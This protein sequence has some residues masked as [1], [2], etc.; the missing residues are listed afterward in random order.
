MVAAILLGA[1]SI[2][3]TIRDRASR[4]QVAVR[5]R[6]ERQT[7]LAAQLELI[8]A[9]ATELLQRQRWSESLSSAKR[10]EAIIAG[11]ETDGHL[12]QLVRALLRELQLVERMDRARHR[13]T[14]WA[15]THFDHTGAAE[16]F[17]AAFRDYGI[18]VLDLP[19][20][21]AA[22]ALRSK[23][24]LLVP[25][26]VALDDWAGSFN[27]LRRGA[28]ARRLLALADAID[29]SPWRRGVRAALL[30]TGSDEDRDAML[31]QLAAT[32]P[33]GD[34][35]PASFWQ[36]ASELRH[37]GHI[38]EATALLRRAQ[39]AR[40]DDYWINFDLATFCDEEASLE[41]AQ[42]AATF[43]RVALAIRPD[44]AAA[45]TGLGNALKAAGKL[46][47]AVDCQRRAIASDPQCCLA[48]VNLGRAL[49]AQGKLDDAI[50]CY[51]K[52]LELV[53]QHAL[54][55]FS[56]GETLR[57]QGRLEQAIHA[58]QRAVA[59]DP[60][61]AAAHNNLGIALLDAGSPDQAIVHF[62]LAVQIDP[63]YVIAYNNL[64][65]AQQAATQLEMAIG[66]YRKSIQLDSRFA[67]AHYNLGNVLMELG[68]LD[69]AAACWKNA[70][71]VDP[72][73]ARPE[74]TGA[75]GNLGIHWAQQGDFDAAVD[76]WTKG[77]D[78]NPRNDQMREYLVRA[79]LTR[80]RQ[81]AEEGAAQRAVDECC[82][83]LQLTADRSEQAFLRLRK[84]AQQLL[85]EALD[86]Q[87]EPLDPSAPQVTQEPFD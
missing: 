70:I 52:V 23:P 6:R 20:D 44:S 86:S 5:E 33:V 10:A 66:S 83:V 18:P 54:V 58:F 19:T 79:V 21:Q 61:Y 55:H 12:Q 82:Q 51:D 3:W 76:C 85:Q 50:D 7:R 2:G 14:A 28:E 47:E 48:W 71:A 46:D 81:R 25:C 24:D 80:A 37:R 22:A 45:L 16:E 68:R 26:A 78:L 74:C 35:G 8:L 29:P 1:G 30:H 60:Q 38:E 39:A 40:A 73:S 27:Q 62:N 49:A 41:L 65:N 4:E 43:F 69:E 11:V 72:K 53:P 77:F 9:D 34:V 31:R 63:S 17:A 64:G 84:E 32:A 13:K 15:V 36:L 57:E 42:E 59:L 75:Y 67:A 87:G 56:L